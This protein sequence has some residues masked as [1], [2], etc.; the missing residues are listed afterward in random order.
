MCRGYVASLIVRLSDK[1]LRRTN[2]A[3]TVH[4][5]HSTNTRNERTKKGAA[6]RHSMIIKTYELIQGVIHQ[7]T[8]EYCD[9]KSFFFLILKGQFLVIISPL[10]LLCQQHSLPNDH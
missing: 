8:V 6:K 3:T 1:T 4:V 5:Q 2:I 10:I 7:S 9:L